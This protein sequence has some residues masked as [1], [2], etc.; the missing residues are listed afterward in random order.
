VNVAE[1]LAREIRRVATLRERY[2]AYALWGQPQA[3]VAPALILMDAALEHACKAAGVDDV[4]A[5]T[6]AGHMLEQFG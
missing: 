3:N 2:H 6:A 1:K 5:Q 4:I